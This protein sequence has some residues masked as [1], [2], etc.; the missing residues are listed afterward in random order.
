[1][2]QPRL[3]LCLSRPNHQHSSPEHITRKQPTHTGNLYYTWHITRHA[4]IL[5]CPPISLYTLQQREGCKVDQH[6]A[7]YTREKISN[8][9]PFSSP[10]MDGSEDSSTAPTTPEGSYMSSPLLRPQILE[11][12]EM[13]ITQTRPVRNICCVGA[14][15]VGKSFEFA[16][17]G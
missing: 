7:T 11:S 9:N 12:I 3:Y 17:H 2:A 1:M 5:L 14:G 16:E 6:S 13:G 10:L 4:D 8:M 15:Y